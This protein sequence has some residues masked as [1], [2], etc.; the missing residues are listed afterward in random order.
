MRLAEDL[1]AESCLTEFTDELPRLG[2]FIG[3]V[4]DDGESIETIEVIAVHK[5]TRIVGLRRDVFGT[6]RHAF[7][8]GTDAL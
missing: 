3:L 1:C 5:K 2:A 8:A 4:S 6:G 7:E